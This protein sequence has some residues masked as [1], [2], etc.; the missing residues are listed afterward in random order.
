MQR[1]YSRAKLVQYIVDSLESGAA[2]K[3]LAQSVAAYLIDAGKAADLNSVMRDAQELRA[4]QSGVVEL[5]V[6]SA[7]T[8]DA[9]QVQQIEAVARK[10]YPTA[11]RVTLNQ[12][13]D[14]SVVAGANLSF[15]HATFDLTVRAKLNQLRE[16]ITHS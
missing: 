2:S 7:H 15:P 10:Q 11:R 5:D 6:R 1:N 4:Q 9:A 3:T 16:G 8:L 12:I 13:H 14:D